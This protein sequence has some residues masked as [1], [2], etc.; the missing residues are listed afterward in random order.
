MNSYKIKTGEDIDL[1]EILV[2]SLGTGRKASKLEI[3]DIES[4]GQIKWV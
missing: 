3:E 1:H 4:W 2:V